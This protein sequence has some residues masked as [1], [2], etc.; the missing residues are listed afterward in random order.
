MQPRTNHAAIAGK[1]DK[2]KKKPSPT[3]LWPQNRRAEW[4]AARPR[5]ADGWL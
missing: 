4:L 3:N 1:E 5:L 2:N